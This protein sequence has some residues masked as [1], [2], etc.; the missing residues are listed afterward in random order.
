MREILGKRRKEERGRERER[1]GGVEGVILDSFEW[2]TGRQAVIRSTYWRFGITGAGWLPRGPPGFIDLSMAGRE[3]GEFTTPQVLSSAVRVITRLIPG[4]T[5]SHTHRNYIS[6]LGYA[7][8]TF[9]II[10]PAPII[11]PDPAKTFDN[12]LSFGQG[13]LV[14]FLLNQCF[15]R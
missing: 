13:R 8:A 5:V 11:Q 3:N 9:V 6:V 2:Y 4:P 1:E 14:G 15:S 10:K 7:R 12:S